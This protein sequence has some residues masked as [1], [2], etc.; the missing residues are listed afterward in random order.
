MTFWQAFLRGFTAIFNPIPMPRP[1]RFER[2]D[3]AALA[4]DWQAVG[5]DMRR[6]IDKY[7]R[8]QGIKDTPT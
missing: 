6:A 4:R 7:K 5:G 1:R 8:E 3:R 2:D